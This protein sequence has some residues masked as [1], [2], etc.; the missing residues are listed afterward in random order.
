MF[1]GGHSPVHG[2]CRSGAGP[3]LGDDAGGHGGPDDVVAAVVLAGDAV[4]ALHVDGVGQRGRAVSVRRR[5]QAHWAMVITSGMKLVAG[6]VSLPGIVVKTPGTPLR[7]ARAGVRPWTG[8][9]WY[10]MDSNGI[11]SNPTQPIANAFHRIGIDTIAMD[12]YPFIAS[13]ADA[14][15]AR[16]HAAGSGVPAEHGRRQAPRNE[17]F[18]GPCWAGKRRWKELPGALLCP[19]CKH[20]FAAR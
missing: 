15:E 9:Q 10:A 5:R 8:T 6:I 2:H 7:L 17:R 12:T 13:G 1:H 4:E 11:V 20:P 3:D 18:C 16:D 19:I 14:V